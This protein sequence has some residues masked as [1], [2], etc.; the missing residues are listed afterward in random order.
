MGPIHFVRKL[1]MFCLNG[2]YFWFGPI[3]KLFKSHVNYALMWILRILGPIKFCKGP[4]KMLNGPLKFGNLHVFEWDMGHRPILRAHH[5]FGLGWTL[6]LYTLRINNECPWVLALLNWP[7]LLDCFSC[8]RMAENG[9][10]PPP[11]GNF[12]DISYLVENWKPSLLRDVCTLC[13]GALV[14]KSL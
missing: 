3:Y 2:L 9:F 4:I 12:A 8:R 14:C 6:G 5:H 10:A 1:L 13:S 11:L 7:L